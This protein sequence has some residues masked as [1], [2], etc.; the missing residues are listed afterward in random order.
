[1]DALVEFG[2]NVCIV[3]IISID[4]VLK[5]HIKKTYRGTE[6]HP[7]TDLNDGHLQ[8]ERTLFTKHSKNM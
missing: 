3:D 5:D 2:G 6:K 7:Y 8:Y 4:H 1:M